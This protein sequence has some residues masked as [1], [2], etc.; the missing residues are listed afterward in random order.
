LFSVA[1]TAPCAQ[2]ATAQ[3][4]VAVSCALSTPLPALFLKGGGRVFCF[5][6]DLWSSAVKDRLLGKLACLAS[7]RQAQ[8]RNVDKFSLLAAHGD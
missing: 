6:A 2:R 8:S 1:V 7:D 3:V 5:L 4:A